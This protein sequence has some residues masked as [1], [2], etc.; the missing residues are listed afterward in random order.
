MPDGLTEGNEGNKVQTLGGIVECSLA[1]SNGSSNANSL[2]LR[3]LC[4]TV[5][6]LRPTRWSYFQGWHLLL[7]LRASR[8]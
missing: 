7:M 6:Q 2:C 3:L 1:L 5:G 8:R 4:S